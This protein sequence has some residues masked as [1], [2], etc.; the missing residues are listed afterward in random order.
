MTQSASAL[1]E[2]DPIPRDFIASAWGPS[3][4]HVPQRLGNSDWG[5]IRLPQD[6]AFEVEAGRDACSW[7][8]TLPTTSCRRHSCALTAPSPAAA[9]VMPERGFWRSCAT[10]PRAG[11]M[12]APASEGAASRSVDWRTRV[13]G[14]MTE[15]RSRNFGTQTRP[16]RKRP[17]WAMTRQRRFAGRQSGAPPTLGT[18]ASCGRY[19]RLTDD[20]KRPN[21]VPGPACRIRARGSA[22]TKVAAALAAPASGGMTWTMRSSPPSRPS[23]WA[24]P[25]K[26]W[27]SIKSMSERCYSAS[28]GSERPKGRVGTG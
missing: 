7:T 16:R 8:R 26:R 1:R 12:S 28:A 14:R 21:R 9:A 20:R 2:A 15:L 11:R 22:W 17:S 25:S 23:S 27:A 19:T 13:R 24:L 18:A 10:A 3:R 5:E 4:I 6:V